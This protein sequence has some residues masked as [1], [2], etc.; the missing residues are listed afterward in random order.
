MEH[1]VDPNYH[2]LD[3]IDKWDKA[4]Q[5]IIK[6]RLEKEIDRKENFTFLTKKEGAKLIKLI[7]VLLPQ[8]E[9][10]FKIKIA[11]SIDKSL[12]NRKTGVK[13][14]QDPWRG[15]FYKKGLEMLGESFSESWLKKEFENPKE[16]FLSRFL[17]L[18]LQDSISIYY[19]HPFA[20]DKIGFP[21][22][23]YPEGYSY[24]GCLEK[25]IW[26]PKYREDRS[27]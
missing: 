10:K 21:G 25:D 20:W 17:R 15:D 18:V 12:S 23:A 5:G 24:L 4:T 19:S 6:N 1:K 11:E 13:Y 8:L 14:G 27:L 3:R 9:S 26:E 22:P 2:S 16:S 7:N